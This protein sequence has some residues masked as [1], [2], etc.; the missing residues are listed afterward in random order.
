MAQDKRMRPCAVSH[1]K[2]EKKV[3]C[4]VQ[5]VRIQVPYGVANAMGI[6]MDM[7]TSSG[8]GG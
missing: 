7:K 6:C 8:Q 5:D 4:H 3:F 2:V 1:S